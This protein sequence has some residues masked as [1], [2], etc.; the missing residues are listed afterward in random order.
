[1]LFVHDRDRVLAFC[2]GTAAPLSGWGA[3]L[4][5]TLV[6]GMA[7]GDI[8]GDGFPEIL[9]Q[10]IH[11]KV[12]YL[13]QSGRP[14]PGWPRAGTPESFRTTSPP[15]AVD[16]TG[17]GHPEAVALNASGVIAA[18]DGAGHVPDGWP[19]ATGVGCAGAPL[20]VDLFGPGS[21]ALVAP[22][23]LGRLYAYV[24]PPPGTLISLP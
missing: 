21:P 12:G 3:P 20:A 15:L 23:R 24:L 22:D 10:S 13:N 2:P 9:V 14:S 16:L 8:D 6:A 1:T 18:F 17:D 4:G 11:S 19:L 5:D 7:A